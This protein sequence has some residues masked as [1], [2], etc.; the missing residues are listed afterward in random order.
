MNDISMGQFSV[1]GHAVVGHGSSLTVNYQRSQDWQDFLKRQKKLREKIA[2][3][4]DDS[5][6]KVELAELLQEM[7]GFK[8]N[9]LKLAEDINKIPLNT[10]R[11]RLAVQ[12]FNANEYAKARSVLDVP[13][14]ELELADLLARQRQLAAQQTDVQTA[15]D[16]K[17][18]EFLLLADLR[19]I[20]YTLGDQRIAKT[21]EA[22]E[23][24]L[25]SGRTPQRLFHYAGYWLRLIAAAARRPKRSTAKP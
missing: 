25:K 3:H 6:Y 24:A 1:G 17:A 21:R 4:P 20:D 22:F 13:E 23:Q 11:L 5:D 7:E 18:N 14:L 10:E 2:K 9:I 16:D 15:L 12:H 8:R 19:A